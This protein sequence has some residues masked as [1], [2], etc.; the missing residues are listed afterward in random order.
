MFRFVSRESTSNCSERLRKVINGLTQSV[1]V[2]NVTFRHATRNGGRL[3]CSSHD[4]ALRREVGLR[5]NESSAVR[6]QSSTARRVVRSVGLL[7]VLRYRRVLRVLRR[8]SSENV[9]SKVKASKTR[10]NVASV[11]TRAA[12]LR[13]TLRPNSNVRGLVRVPFLPARR[14][15]RGTRDYLTPCAQRLKGLPRYLF[16]WYE[17]VLLRRRAESGCQFP[18]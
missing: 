18:P 12:M 10:L 16:R 14:G 11:V 1:R 15:G 3:L 7:N 13:L 4:R 8:T 2:N 5:I 9:T 17:E 6:Q